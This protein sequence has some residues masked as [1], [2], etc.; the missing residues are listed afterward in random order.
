VTTRRDAQTIYYRLA[1]RDAARV[2][3][4]LADIYCPPPRRLSERPRPAGGRPASGSSPTGR[5]R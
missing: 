3:R 1:N 5:N 4:V 2:L